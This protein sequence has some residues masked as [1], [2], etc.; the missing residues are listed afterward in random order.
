MFKLICFRKNTLEITKIHKNTQKIMKFN[1]NTLKITRFRKN[2][3]NIT[4]FGKNTSK[5]TNCICSVIT[6]IIFSFRLLPAGLIWTFRFQ[7]L[8][9]KIFQLIMQMP[10]KISSLNTPLGVDEFATGACAALQFALCFM[11]VMFLNVSL[12]CLILCQL[13]TIQC[14][15]CILSFVVYVFLG[16]TSMLHVSFFFCIFSWFYDT[17]RIEHSS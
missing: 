13:P 16:L 1:K 9:W 11:C 15:F 7:W 12:A 2:T 5:I 6:F 3:L 10:Q 4:T 17:R 14:M 8:T